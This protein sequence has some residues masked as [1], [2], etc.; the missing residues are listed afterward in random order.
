MIKPNKTA[1]TNNKITSMDVI[2]EAA[3]D[4][5]QQQIPPTI[6]GLKRMMAP[7]KNV[8]MP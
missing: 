4:K 2:K 8:G 5:S 1:G 3:M 7:D 6:N